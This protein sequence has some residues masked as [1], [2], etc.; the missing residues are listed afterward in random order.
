MTTNQIYIKL[1]LSTL[2][3]PNASCLNLDYFFPPFFFFLKD[4][5]CVSNFDWYSALYINYIFSIV[6]LKSSWETL[7]HTQVSHSMFLPKHPDRDSPKPH[8]VCIMPQQ[9]KH[10]P[11]YLQ[12]AA[13]LSFCQRC[14]LSLCLWTNGQSRNMALLCVFNIKKGK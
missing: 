11:Q 12:T 2:F 14:F 3:C 6:S 4:T 13:Q 7:L 5:D 10:N 1:C 8:N 9:M